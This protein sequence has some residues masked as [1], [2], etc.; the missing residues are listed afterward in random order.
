MNALAK[1]SK[2][3]KRLSVIRQL[4]LVM[5][6]SKNGT[7]R[8]ERL[9]LCKC[10]C[11]KIV[12]INQSHLKSGRIISC[13]CYKKEGYH[14]I[15]HGMTYTSEYAAWENLRSRCYN[16]NNRMYQWY[17]KL[18]ITV[19]ERWKKSFQSFINSMGHKPTPKHTIE[20]RNVNKGYTPSNCYWATYKIQSR[21]KTSTIRVLYKEE[22]LPLIDICEKLSLSY[23]TVKNRYYNGWRGDKL[24]SPIKN[25]KIYE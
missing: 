11:G 5:I 7:E 22:K 14:N 17:G 1:L 10:D 25:N 3:Y 12:E 6:I 18:G 8:F 16:K 23:T 15:T 24:F 20:R 21:N 9:V 4:P 19:C 13:G 2:R